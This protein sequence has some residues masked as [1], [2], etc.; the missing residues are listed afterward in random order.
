MFLHVCVILFT[1]VGALVQGGV[2]S[3]VGV[4][5]GGGACSGG[6][7]LRGGACSE[8]G[9]GRSRPTPQGKVEGGSGPGPHP[10]G[11]LRGIRSRPPPTATTADGT[12]PTGM[13]SCLQNLYRKLNENEII[14]TKRRRASLAPLPLDR[15]LLFNFA[16]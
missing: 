9:G 15:P 6:S 4:W 3:G 7:G 11:N 5:S 12:H 16:L 13:H 1:G 2:C 10:R 14:W 8:G